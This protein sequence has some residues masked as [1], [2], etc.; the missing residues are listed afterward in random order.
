[1]EPRLFSK[2]PHVYMSLSPEV[3]ALVM[4]G[5]G[6]RLPTGGRNRV[7]IEAEVEIWYQIVSSL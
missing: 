3:V 2:G 5:R 4:I 1:M 6:G 7:V